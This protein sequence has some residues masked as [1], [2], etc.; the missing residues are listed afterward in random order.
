MMSSLQ[1]VRQLF[2]ISGVCL[3]GLGIFPMGASASYDYPFPDAPL[4]FPPLP[5]TAVEPMIPPSPGWI[6]SKVNSSSNVF[7]VTDGNYQSMFIVTPTGVTVVDAPEPLPFFPPLPVI[8]AVRSV[9]SLAITRVIY[10]HA[11]TDH[12]GGAGQIKAKFPNVEIIAQEQTKRILESEN[13][14]RRPIPTRT[15]SDRLVLDLG[16][17]EQLELSYFGPIHVEGNSFIYLPRQKILMVVDVVFPGW[18]P[19]KGLALST[20]VGEWAAAYDLILKFDFDA[21]VSG[22]L[23]RL[24]NRQDV[25]VGKE[26]I[27]DIKNFVEAAYLDQNTLFSAVNAINGVQGPGFASRT[28]ATWA[29]FSGFFDFSVKECAD[30]LD[31]K[32]LGVLGGAET[33]DFSNCEAWFIARRLGTESWKPHP[34]PQPNGH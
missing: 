34:E 28:V 7:L 27:N 5:Q 33:F 2:F 10:S 13:D 1:T 26:Y 12:I 16:G 21:L 8:D 17:G 29:E 15:F 32:W 4:Q 6:V 14:P 18:V 25:V 9:T 23:G 19:F 3:L 24:G 11:H 30:K 31:A 20:N 22:H